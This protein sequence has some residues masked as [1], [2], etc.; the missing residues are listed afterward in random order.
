MAKSLAT[1]EMKSELAGGS[2]FASFRVRG[3][4]L[5]P[6]QITHL[7]HVFPTTAYAKGHKYMAGA[8]T[9]ELIGR[10]GVWLLSTRGIVA[11]ENLIHHLEFIIRILVPDTKNFGPLIGLNMLL[12]KHKDVRADVSC[13]WHGRFGERRPSI[14]KTISDLFKLVPADIELDFDTDSQEADRR[15]A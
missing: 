15:R 2:P 12:L 10:T 13:F 7:L 1:S 6:D 9:G 3:D 8:G 5:D 4:A 14:P 11:S